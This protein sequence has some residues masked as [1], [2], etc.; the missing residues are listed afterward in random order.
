MYNWVLKK[1]LE[2]IL[3]YILKIVKM[4]LLLLWFF[5]FDFYCDI[6]FVVCNILCFFDDLVLVNVFLSVI[7]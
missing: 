2:I 1:I 3:M 4:V 5:M 6:K 7:L